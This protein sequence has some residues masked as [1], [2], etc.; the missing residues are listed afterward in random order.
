M[1]LDGRQA[2]YRMYKNFKLVCVVENVCFNNDQ[3]LKLSYGSRTNQLIATNFVDRQQIFAVTWPMVE[4]N[5]DYR[6]FIAGWLLFM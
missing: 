3:V 2:M 4:P 6:R 5:S 1:N